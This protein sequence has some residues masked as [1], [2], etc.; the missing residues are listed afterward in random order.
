MAY[1]LPGNNEYLDFG[2]G[3]LS[4]TLAGPTWMAVG[5]K[6]NATTDGAAIHLL[7]SLD[8][9]GAFLECFGSWDFGIGATARVG[10]AGST[11]G[12]RVI[13]FTKDTGTVSVEW[14]QIILGGATTSGTATGGTLAN[15]GTPPGGTGKIRVGRFQVSATE[16]L[17]AEIFFTAVGNG[18]LNQAGRE[19]LT[20]W[21]NVLAAAN[22]A[23]AVEYTGIG[24]RVDATGG[25]GNETGR[26]GT[27]ITLVADPAGFFGGALGG[28][29]STVTETDTALTLPRTKK[30]VIPTVIDTGT[31]L[32]LGKL[33]RR[34]LVVVTEADTAQTLTKRKIRILSP[35]VETSTTQPLTRVKKKAFPVVA[36]TETVLT[37]GRKKIRSLGIVGD[38]STALPFSTP[39][40]I[41]VAL[42][43]V[44]EVD[45]AL[46]LQRVKKRTI[47][48]VFESDSAFAL[49]KLK[50]RLLP[51][52][53]EIDLAL[54]I[55]SPNADTAPPDMIVRTRLVTTMVQT[56]QSSSI[57]QSSPG[58]TV[59][60]TA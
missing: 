20:T 42:T 54:D 30:R 23:W 18:Y 11:S 39:G 43:T 17:N 51:V 41:I 5:C 29:F 27:S 2:V 52:V 60:V 16:Y 45:T 53:G 15:G 21:A 36:E 58:T 32:A 49:A 24:S 28:P 59:V 38:T 26:F 6:L 48:M 31:A 47:P 19:G 57:V 34:A 10:P 8:A 7:T 55:E 14:S 40:D 37:V 9:S 4:A 13:V 25:G 22:W 35:V 12:H 50:K 1:S 44:T 46:T 33:K 56:A 3:A